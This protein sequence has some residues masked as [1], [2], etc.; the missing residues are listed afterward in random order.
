VKQSNAKWERI[1]EAEKTRKEAVTR[2]FRFLQKAYNAYDKAM[3]YRIESAAL[4]GETIFGH[5]AE[6][7]NSH[8]REIDELRDAALRFSERVG[9]HGFRK[10]IEA[11]DKAIN[12]ELERA[13]DDA[14]L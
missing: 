12:K 9:G 3:Q 5:N 6:V 8:Q 13:Q 10:A 14:L 2:E 1:R 11:M 7:G 4:K